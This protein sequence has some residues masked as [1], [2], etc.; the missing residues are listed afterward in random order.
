MERTLVLSDDTL[1]TSGLILLTLVAVELGGLVVL[2]MTRGHQPAT[3]F[4]R[5]FA[6]AGHGHAGVL[7]V[8][9]LVSQILAD[10]AD[11]SGVLE[12]FARTGIWVAA[13][14]MSVGF[15]LASAGKDVHEANRLI[16]VVYAGA[17]ALALGVVSLG[18]G[19]LRA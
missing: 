5:A 1:G 6:R 15:F 10:A 14:L 16:V 8:L 2:R 7:L 12:F 19:L 17:V 3:P 4:Q 13:I 9:A 11:L 18:I